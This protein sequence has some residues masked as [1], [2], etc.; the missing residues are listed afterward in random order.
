MLAEHIAIDE[1]KF[2]SL[3][4][5]WK[6]NTLNNWYGQIWDLP[7][8]HGYCEFATGQLTVKKS[9]SVT[10]IKHDLS[11]LYKAKMST[12]SAVRSP[13]SIP[14]AF[15]RTPS[16]PG[17]HI[18]LDAFIWTARIRDSTLGRHT[19]GTLGSVAPM[20]WGLLL[21]QLDLKSQKFSLLEAEPCK[22]WPR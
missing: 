12:F 9:V 3:R 16:Q 22:R 11:H 4:Y 13:S 2:Q 5:D 21:C 7:R 1:R 17:P 10:I 19:P 18:S 20:P 15:P 8:S 14:P 6:A